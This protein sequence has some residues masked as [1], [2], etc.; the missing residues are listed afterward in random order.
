MKI[1]FK[2]LICFVS[3]ILAFNLVWFLFS[4]FKYKSFKDA[5]GYDEQKQSWQY[6]DKEHV[7]GV[8]SPHYLSFTGNLSVTN[9]RKIDKDGNHLDE[10]T[11]SMIIWPKINGKYDYGVTVGIRQDDKKVLK[12]YNFMLDSKMNSIE[13]LTEEEQQILDNAKSEITLLY[14]K[15]KKMWNSLPIE[16]N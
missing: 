15:T 11:Y 13:E 16:L 8:S 10:Y 7:F 1:K 5:V 6:N 2:I 3:L 12:A 9:I 14:Q 4:H